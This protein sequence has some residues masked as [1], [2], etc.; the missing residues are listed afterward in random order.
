MFSAP[1]MARI[2][3][4][5]SIH[6]IDHHPAM[7]F[8]NWPEFCHHPRRST[9]PHTSRPRKGCTANQ[10]EISQDR[11]S[12]THGPSTQTCSPSWH[13]DDLTLPRKILKDL[14]TS[15][16]FRTPPTLAAAGSIS[17]RC[18]KLKKTRQPPL[19]QQPQFRPPHSHLRK[20]SPGL[21]HL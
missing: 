1:S 14:P 8:L 6:L 7:S 5:F 10:E 11:S 3:R 21:T 13:Y 19:P 2:W 17:R 16:R 9:P 12:P 18:T 15:F 20:S 4:T